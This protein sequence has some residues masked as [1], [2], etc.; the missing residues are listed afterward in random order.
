MLLIRK[1]QKKQWTQ[2]VEKIKERERL[3]RLIEDKLKKLL[4]EKGYSTRW[5]KANFS[6]WK[7]RS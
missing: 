5:K 2:T 1:T 4:I 7:A 3:R 6:D